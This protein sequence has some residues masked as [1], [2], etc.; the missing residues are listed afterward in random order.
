MKIISLKNPKS[1]ISEAY[2]NVRTNIEFSNLDKDIKVIMVTSSK[3]NEG[4]STVI[5]NLAVSFSKLED[6]KI[7][8]IDCDLRN[9]TVH[10]TFGISNIFGLTDTLIGNKT[11]EEC[12]GSISE[13]NIDILTAGKIPP[14][15]SEILGSSKMKYF[16]NSIRDDYDYIFIDAPPIGIVTD[17]GVMSNFID[18]TILVVASNETDVEV[19]KIAKERLEHVN[20]N[21]LGVI[22]NKFDSKDSAYGYYGYYNES[23]R[24]MKNSKKKRFSLKNL[25]FSIFK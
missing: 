13:A 4:K 25:G 20:A 22:L 10:R 5:S 8:I 19:V 15:P 18:G 7:L 9:P 14:N 11:F 1:P 24:Q 21:I 6:K 12:V 16:I 2:R 23:E 3:Q 17:A